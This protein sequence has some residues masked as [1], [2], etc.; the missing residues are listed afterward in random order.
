M[1]ELCKVYARRLTNGETDYQR[2]MIMARQVYKMFLDQ[3]ETRVFLGK[4][5][6]IEALPLAQKKYLYG[7]AAGFCSTKEQAIEA[8]KFIYIIDLM[9]A[10]LVN[11]EK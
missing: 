6:P 4:I 11:Q 2:I 5:P 7:I 9:A 10:E 1:R 8:C 3:Y